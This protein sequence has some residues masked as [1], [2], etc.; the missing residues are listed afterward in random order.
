MNIIVKRTSAFYNMIGVI[1]CI[2]NVPNVIFSYSSKS[3]NKQ[4]KKKLKK[5]PVLSQ[6]SNYY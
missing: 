2:R 1:I 5:D 3:M 6:K 4:K